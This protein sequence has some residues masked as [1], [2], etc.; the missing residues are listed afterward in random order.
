MFDR[1]SFDEERAAEVVHSAKDKVLEAL[2]AAGVEVSS[3]DL[4]DDD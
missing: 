3:P 1:R 2:E 4:P